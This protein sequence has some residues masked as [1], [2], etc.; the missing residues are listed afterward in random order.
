VQSEGLI[1][2]SLARLAL[3]DQELLPLGSV[4]DAAAAR[5]CELVVLRQSLIESL[6][7]LLNE[8][9]PVDGRPA[10]LWEI[11]V[12][13]A[14]LEQHWR[15]R[16]QEWAQLLAGSDLHLRQLRLFAEPS[17]TDALLL[18]RLG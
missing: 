10:G 5:L 12:S 16:R 15:D 4:D 17:S 7:R 14:R 2:G 8:V 13:T 6:V 11:R 18:D 9:V 3:L 1:A